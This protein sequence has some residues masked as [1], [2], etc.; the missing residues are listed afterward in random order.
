VVKIVLGG[1]VGAFLIF[2]MMT[3]PDQAAHIAKGSWHFVNT[4]AHRVG[5]FVDKLSS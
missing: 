4:M 2:Y 3:S 5:H 1:L